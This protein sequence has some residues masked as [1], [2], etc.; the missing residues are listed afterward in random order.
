MQSSGPPPFVGLRSPLVS[1]PLRRC[2]PFVAHSRNIKL[3][4]KPNKHTYNVEVRSEQL[5]VGRGG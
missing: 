4:S 5:R 3:Y 2:V 1:A